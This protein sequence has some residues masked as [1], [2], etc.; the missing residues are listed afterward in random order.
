MR[1][2]SS[3][4]EALIER[5]GEV[6]PQSGVTA[7]RHY[8]VFM[9]RNTEYHCRNGVCVAVRDRKTGEWVTDHQALD[10]PVISGLHFDEQAG[11]QFRP[12]EI[13]DPLVFYTNKARRLMT[14]P[15]ESI[16]RPDDDDLPA[17]V[18]QRS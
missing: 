17:S 16:A 1:P 14:S 7:R 11:V 4:S 15:I 9:T 13:G 10:L 18:S 3:G 5:P 12:P 6:T 8:H 2:F